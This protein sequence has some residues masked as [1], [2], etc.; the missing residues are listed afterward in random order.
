MKQESLDTCVAAVGAM[1]LNCGLDYAYEWM[2]KYETEPFSLVLL[3]FFLSAHGIFMGLGANLSNHDIYDSED[4]I[5]VKFKVK[6]FEAV[7]GVESERI[8]G[9]L[10][11]VYWDGTK[12]FDSSPYS[13]DGRPLGDYILVDW[14][15]IQ[16]T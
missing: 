2:T 10:H 4:D 13:E 6:D 3:Q 5:T 15:P 1:I 16:R 9:A 11:V 14:W 12:V 8:E 7:V